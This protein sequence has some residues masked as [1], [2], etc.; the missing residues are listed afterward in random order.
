MLRICCEYAS[1]HLNRYDLFKKAQGIIPGHHPEGRGSVTIGDFPDQLPAR[2]VGEE[3]IHS[4]AEKI[5]GSA[6][7]PA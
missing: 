4:P 7:V 3:G 1:A 6:Q 5:S 2:Q